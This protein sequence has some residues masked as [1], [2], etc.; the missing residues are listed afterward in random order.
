MT[1]YVPVPLAA[2]LA[3]RLF[4]TRL[5]MVGRRRAVWI[6]TALVAAVPLTVSALVT[7]TTA[8]TR[9]PAVL[10]I[11]F[12]PESTSRPPSRGEVA[13][14]RH[15]PLGRRR[16]VSLAG[17]LILIAYPRDQLGLPIKLGIVAAG[18]AMAI[19]GLILLE[20]R[21]GR[22]WRWMQSRPVKWIGRRTYGVYLWH[23]AVMGELYVLF[24]HNPH[25]GRT[26]VALLPLVLLGTVAVAELSWRFVER[27]A[28]RLQ[29][30]RAVA[31]AE[32]APPA[33]PAEPVPIRSVRPA[34]G[35]LATGDPLRG[36]A[37]LAIMTVHLP[38]GAVRDRLSRRRGRHAAAGAGVRVARRAR[39]RRAAR[40]GLPLLRPV[41]LPDHATVRGG[42]RGRRPA[43]VASFLRAQPRAPHLPRG[44]GA[45][46]LRADPLRRPRIKPRRAAVRAHAD[47]DVHRDPLESLV[48]QLWSLKVELS[49]Y[50]SSRSCSWRCRSFGRIAPAL[51]R[52]ALYFVA[53]TGACVSVGLSA[54]VGFS[55]AAQRT[56]PWTLIAFMSGLALAT[57][58]AG[59]E[60]R[61]ATR[62]RERSPRVPSRAA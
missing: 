17:M 46:R 51:R 10:L 55:F 60:R 12:M 34:G 30:P 54:E 45:P 14:T 9:S 19:G 4:G 58:L 3:V 29:S 18:A 57:V 22:P 25:P 27:P 36:L 1:F 2:A 28:M 48:G 26:Y 11:L 53:A 20:R 16:G 21:I 52:P 8:A 33:A 24:S 13:G 15:A 43:P 47:R 56:L 44:L 40:L 49:F 59:C 42:V 41:G 32:A 31:A 62:A 23:L 6:A 7:R 61:P 50:L 35:R 5:G 38:R 39:A 37:V